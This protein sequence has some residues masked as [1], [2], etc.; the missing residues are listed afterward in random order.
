MSIR[1]SIDNTILAGL[2]V[3]E[4][5]PNIYYFF[6]PIIIQLKKLELGFNLS[7]ENQHSETKRFLIADKPAKSA[8]LNINDCNGFYG[9]HVCYQPGISHREQGD[10]IHNYEFKPKN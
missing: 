6:N 3:G 1:F 7:I 8:V 10:R 9:C 5:K 2:S 4:E